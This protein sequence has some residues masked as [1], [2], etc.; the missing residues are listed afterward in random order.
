[1]REQRSLSSKEN[2][3]VMIAFLTALNI[4]SVDT[5]RLVAL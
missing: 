3:A 5:N 2:S 1:M 4:Q